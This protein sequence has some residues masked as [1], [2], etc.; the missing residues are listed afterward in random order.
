MRCQLVEA[1]LRRKEALV[2]GNIQNP[3]S[4]TRGLKARNAGM[5][6]IS[7]FCCICLSRVAVAQGPTYSAD[8][9]MAAFEKGSKISLKGNEITFTDVV[10]EN[11]KA[12]VIFKSSENGRVVC[13]LV[14]PMD[15]R[16]VELAVG[17]PL[18]VVGKPRGRGIFGNVTLDECRVV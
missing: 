5:F 12:K 13:E 18:T 7:A 3:Y 2:T 15:N 17:S 6:L 11:K 1:S 9:L 14:S 8:S 4:K 16:N 10:I